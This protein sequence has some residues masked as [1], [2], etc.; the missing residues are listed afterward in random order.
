MNSILAAIKED[1]KLSFNHWRY[2]LLHWYFN[3]SPT[4]VEDSPINR[5][6][7]THYCPLF[8][9]TNLI[10]IFSPIIMLVKFFWVF[11]EFAAVNSVKVYCSVRT[12]ARS[13]LEQ[14]GFKEYLEQRNQLLVDKQVATYKKK[15]HLKAIKA[16][17]NILMT[18]GKK[19]FED[20][21]EFAIY[22]RDAKGEDVFNYLK[23]KQAE[24]IWEANKNQIAL[25]QQRQLI[26][27]ERQETLRK[28]RQEQLAF[29]VGFSRI[30]IKG[31]LNVIYGSLF[32]G[33]CYGTYLAIAPTW[34]ALCWIGAGISAVFS[35]IMSISIYDTVAFITNFG[36]R[37]IVLAGVLYLSYRGLKAIPFKPLLKK[38]CLPFE[39]V[40]QIGCSFWKWSND[41]FDNSIEFVKMFYEENC[42]AIVIVKESEEDC[43]ALVKE[44]S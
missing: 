23:K 28:R 14:S 9:I 21:W 6:F 25:I 16:F 1:H 10:A 7:Y 32:L 44:E 12:A 13:L 40:G 11:G 34:F 5:V 19:D 36:F 22:L 15:M 4:C 39:V 41:T 27:A 31:S 20:C 43:H 35:W 24:N 2:R 3:V 30:F 8:H 42:P 26:I 37:G 38:S 17:K 29:W 33:V 18:A